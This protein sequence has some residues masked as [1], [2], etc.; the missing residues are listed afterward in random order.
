MLSEDFVVSNGSQ[1]FLHRE[2]VIVAR[3]N[4]IGRHLACLGRSSGFVLV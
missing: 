4:A 2:I 1:G 3:L